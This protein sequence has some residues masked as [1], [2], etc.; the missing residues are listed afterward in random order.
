MESLIEKLSS[1]NIL[2]N[3]IPG[4][5]F[6]FMAKL[7]DIV[8]LPVNGIVESLFVYYFCG[9]IISRIG[10]LVI[11]TV[12]K[13]FKWIEYAPKAKYVDAVKKDARIE[14]LLETSNMYRTCAG[15]FLTL[16][17]VKGYLT[18]AGVIAIPKH[19]TIWLVIVA[20]LALFSA[21]FV[22]Q[23]RHI[24]SRV[25]AANKTTEGR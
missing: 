6:V 15:L 19:I 22:K 10:S 7:L 12:F 3:L 17:A 8:F 18:L 25:D 20:L 23:T 11:E 4:A 14:T 21:S 24:G 13:K 1:Y 9:M 16:G 2:N 5:V